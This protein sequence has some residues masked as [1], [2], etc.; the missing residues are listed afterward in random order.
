MIRARQAEWE[1]GRKRITGAALAADA[2]RGMVSLFYDAV[3]DV[4][5]RYHSPLA[6][7]LAVALAHEMG[8]ALLPPPSHTSI[9]IMRA[10]WEGDDLRHAGVGSLTFS[11]AEAYAIRTKAERRCVATQD[12]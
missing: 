5:L 4:A 3:T 2:I 12:P 10:A 11:E 1:P 7:V 6:D 9:G 8:H